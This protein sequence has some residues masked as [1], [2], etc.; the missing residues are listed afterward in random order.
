MSAFMRAPQANL[1][2]ENA[3]GVNA[4]RQVRDARVA[5]AALL[6]CYPEEV[7]DQ[8]RHWS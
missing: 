3:G 1:G 5:A 2:G 4:V 8:V 7:R 6:N